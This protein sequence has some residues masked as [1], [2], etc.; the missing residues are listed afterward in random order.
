MTDLSIYTYLSV[1]LRPTCCSTRR[2]TRVSVY[3]SIFLAVVFAP[4]SNL[5]LALSTCACLFVYWP[6]LF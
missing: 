5:L 4:P 3:V 1:Y 6:F 2:S